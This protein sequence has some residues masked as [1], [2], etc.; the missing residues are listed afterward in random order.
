[1]KLLRLMRRKNDRPRLSGKAVA[2]T[3]CRFVFDSFKS[4]SKRIAEYGSYRG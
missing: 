1:M 2:F 4:P 3:G